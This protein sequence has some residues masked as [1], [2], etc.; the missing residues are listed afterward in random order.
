MYYFILNFLSFESVNALNLFFVLKNSC[1]IHGATSLSQIRPNSL[2]LGYPVSYLYK[3]LVD[4]FGDYGVFILI[5][6]SPKSVLDHILF[7][8]YNKLYDEKILKDFKTYF[9]VDVNN[10]TEKKLKNLMDSYYSSVEN[11][12]GNKLIVIDLAKHNNSFVTF[13]KSP[14]FLEVVDKLNNH[15]VSTDLSLKATAIQTEQIDRMIGFIKDY[16][17]PS[18]HYGLPDTYGINK[19]MNNNFNLVYTQT[20]Q[21]N[22]NSYLEK[23]IEEFN[24]EP[25]MEFLWD[26]QNNYVTAT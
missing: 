22:V 12:V 13:I 21:N 11:T 3:E 6:E 19:W 17:I 2:N 24:N 15:S 7:G 10:I 5:K 18:L 16:F 26:Q 9:D 1:S 14:D 25:T 20:D 23:F 4:L 8:Y